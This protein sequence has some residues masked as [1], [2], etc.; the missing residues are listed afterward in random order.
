MKDASSTPHISVLS[1]DETRHWHSPFSAVLRNLRRAR[2]IAECEED[3]MKS[4]R[5]VIVLYDA[6][7]TFLMERAVG[8]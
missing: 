8:E 1:L 2:I 7:E 4:G 3:A 5:E 6:N